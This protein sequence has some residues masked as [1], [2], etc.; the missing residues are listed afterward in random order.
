MRTLLL[1]IFSLLLFSKD[2]ILLVIKEY[3]NDPDYILYESGRLLYRR[4]DTVK[5]K[6]TNSIV[7]NYYELKLDSSMIKNLLDLRFLK[8]SGFR[9][10]DFHIRYI[11][12]KHG[13]DFY[14]PRN[15]I[16]KPKYNER[17]A[18]TFKFLNNLSKDSTLKVKF[19]EYEFF[20]GKYYNHSYSYYKSNFFIK[21][22][23]EM[24]EFDDGYGN[25][26][27]LVLHSNVSLNKIDSLNS[28]NDGLVLFKIEDV[29][30]NLYYIRP[31]IEGLL[32]VTS[33]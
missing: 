16:Y 26:P 8:P 2:D 18:N 28:I 3:R 9:V 22:Q 27:W 6:I 17:H 23:D 11:F 13:E 24:F 21:Y 30:Y 29:Y 5:I 33:F 31:K 32:Q 15:S 1:L 4:L 25:E 7:S 14:L 20:F 10:R 19:N 12:P